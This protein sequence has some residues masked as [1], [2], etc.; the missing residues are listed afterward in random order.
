MHRAYIHISHSYLI[1][2]VDEQHGKAYHKIFFLKICLSDIS[3]LYVI[4]TGVSVYT[5]VIYPL[6]V[7]ILALISM[8]LRILL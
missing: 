2:H 3:L 7:I 4:Y 1:Y 5:H 8:L 6:Y